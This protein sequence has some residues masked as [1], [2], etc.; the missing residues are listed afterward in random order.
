MFFDSKMTE[1]RV[2]AA[3]ICALWCSRPGCAFAK[4]C[5]RDACTTICAATKGGDIYVLAAY[6]VADERIRRYF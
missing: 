4:A 1:C 6:T 2:R 3:D 5:T